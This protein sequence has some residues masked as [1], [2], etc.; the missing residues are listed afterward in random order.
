MEEIEIICEWS[1]LFMVK[2]VYLG[3]SSH[4]FTYWWIYIFSAHC[5]LVPCS[6]LTHSTDEDLLDIK[7]K[8][9]AKSQTLSPT[10]DTT[11]TRNLCVIK[12][13]LLACSTDIDIFKFIK[14]LLTYWQEIF[15]HGS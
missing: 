14:S 9:D 12:V 4:G 5:K 3:F 10:S 6:T 8:G 2:N 1:D 13:I 11:E 15:L 7:R